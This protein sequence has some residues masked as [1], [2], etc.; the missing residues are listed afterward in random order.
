VP[1]PPLKVAVVPISLYFLRRTMEEMNLSPLTYGE[2]EKKSESISS[3][4][5]K[6]FK[7]ISPE[8]KSS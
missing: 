4:S 1:Y 7:G 8:R 3:T 2:S 6:V 5:K